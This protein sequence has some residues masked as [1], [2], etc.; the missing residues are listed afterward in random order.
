MEITSLPPKNWKPVTLKPPVKQ[1]SKVV[2]R[3]NNEVNINDYV[4]M[5]VAA[6]QSDLT[7]QQACDYAQLPRSTFYDH[8]KKNPDFA[9]KM[10][11]AKG[12]PLRRA[13]Q[14]AV[15]IIDKGSD[16]DAGPMI[17]WILEKREPET[18]GQRF[19]PPGEGGINNTQ[20]NNYFFLNNGQISDISKQPDVTEG[21]PSEL[22]EAL[23]APSSVDSRPEEESAAPVH[24]EAF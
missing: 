1:W 3:T 11:Q 19:A 6:F 7:T 14:R 21:D 5:L 13:K 12:F 10:R 8:L 22:L 23:E 9:E 2:V 15:D 18:Y 24:Q 17:R 16:R 20:N 4:Q